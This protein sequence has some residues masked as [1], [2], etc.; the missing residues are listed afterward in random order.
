M[1]KSSNSQFWPILGSID[2]PGLQDIVFEIGIYHG[3]K[4]P[5]SSEVFLYF[6]VEEFKRLQECGF[7]YKNCNYRLNISKILCDA[8][9]KSFILGIKSHNAYD[10]CTKCTVEGEFIKNRMSYPD[11]NAPLRTHQK[12]INGDYD[13]YHIRT[14][15][16]TN[17]DI[18]LIDS[19]PLDY[20]YLYMIKG[21]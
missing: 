6:F 17:L 9:A 5:E 1:T 11:L 8:P 14:T 12:F 13:E 19:F 16:L 2:H 3:L 15:P 21:V 10:G 20:M 18:D 7:T 4:K